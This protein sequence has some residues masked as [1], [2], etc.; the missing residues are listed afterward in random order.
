MNAM[1]SA[2]MA[3]GLAAV[4]FGGGCSA[5]QAEA[6]RYLSDYS[7]LTAHPDV[8]GAKRYIAPPAELARYRKLLVEPFSLRPGYGSDLGKVSRSDARELLDSLR[9]RMIDIVGERY[10]VVQ[11]PGDSVLRLR[12]AVTDLK[13]DGPSH[14]PAHAVGATYEAEVVDS[15]TGEQIGAVVRT[16][17]A[18]EGQNAFDAMGALLLKFMND[19][20]GA[21]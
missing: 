19:A 4:L 20:Q 5:L 14:D 17:D 12:A 18:P 3:A 2:L 16:F 9:A 6:D 10:A 13:F 7:K 15:I 8:P 21:Q 11:R 1:R